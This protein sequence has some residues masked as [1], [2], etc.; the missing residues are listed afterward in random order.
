MSSPI[1]SAEFRRLLDRNLREVG[2]SEFDEL[3]DDVE[4]LY[5]MV[6]S[7]RAT[8]EFW[9][10]GAVQDVPEFTGKIDYLPVSPGFHTK[11]EPKEYA[12]G[13][14]FERKL[15]DD[16]QFSVMDDRTR[17]LGQSGSRVRNKIM[18]RPFS[19]A[20]SAA[21]DYQTSEEGVALCSSSHT[22]KSG[23]STS[24]GF[25]NAGSSALSPTSIS[26]TRLAMRRFRSDISE[27]ISLSDDLALIVPDNL[28]DR[29]REIV[30]T[31]KGLDTGNSNVNKNYGRYRVIPLLRL[32]DTSTT[33]WFMVD[34]KQMKRD[35]IWID[36]IKREFKNTVDF[37]NFMWK[38]SIYF[39]LGYGWRDWRW[40]YGHS[41]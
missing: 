8:E 16:K 7:D 35:L 39:R 14:M 4:M 27:R 40:I 22:T 29:A 31:P 21:F 38:V 36:R 34:M 37:E 12:A 11:I 3:M 20:F 30:E 18:V 1:V 41:V 13:Q 24:S 19:L 26:A 23:T 32:D 5:R 33:S 17:G 25:D 10:I 9:N 2:E 28:A 15:L 6:P